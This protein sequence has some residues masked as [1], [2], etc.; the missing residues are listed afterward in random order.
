MKQ[1]TYLF[2]CLMMALPA[3]A[4]NLS[5]TSPDGAL[6]VTVGVD[7]GKAWYQVT[8]GN[9]P[10]INRSEL[11]FVIKDGDLKGNFKMGNVTR[12]SLDETWSQPWG[13]DAQV[14]NHYNEMKVRLQEKKGKKRT[15]DVVFRAY[16]DGVAFRYEY[17]RQPGL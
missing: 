13:E 3:M 5:V 12:T 4:K 7:G 17:P 6:T 11:G 10:I 9:E 2:L 8:R 14:R 16:D 1:L 15:L